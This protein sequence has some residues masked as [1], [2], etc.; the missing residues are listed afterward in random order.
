MVVE[1]IL[2]V[3]LVV[4]LADLCTAATVSIGCPWRYTNI[5]STQGNTENTPTFHKKE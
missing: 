2:E 4:T 5:P 3:Y 1:V